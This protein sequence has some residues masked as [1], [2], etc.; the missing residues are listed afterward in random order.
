[1]RNCLPSNQATGSATMKLSSLVNKALLYFGARLV[2]VKKEPDASPGNVHPLDADSPDGTSIEVR[3]LLNLVAY[4]A[5]NNVSYS[6][7]DFQGAYH[8][9]RIAG[10]EFKGQRD[11]EQR[12]QDVPF[13]F[14]GASVLDLGCNQGGM[15]FSIAGRIK[16]GVGIDYDYKMINAANRI[17]SYG[18]VTNL[19]FYV[20][21]LEKENLELLRNFTHAKVDI[22][23]LLSVCMWLKNWKS[24]INTARSISNVLLFE[25]NGSVEQQQEQ[26]ACLR[27][28]YADVAIVR[29]ASTDD[30]L[31]RKRRLFLCHAHAS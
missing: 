29:E 21:D 31:Q 19:D 11:P 13:N 12:L 9:L 22:V 23:F 20:F 14:D 17:R 18:A 8:T 30:P 27:A 25:S 26:E 10:H 24:V 15:L 2:R 28:T 7:Q 1:M 4:T 5:T 3:K 6:A 16:L